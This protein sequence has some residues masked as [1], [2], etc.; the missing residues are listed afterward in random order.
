VALAVAVS[1]VVISV[2]VGVSS[3]EVFPC[4]SGA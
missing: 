2:I 4:A 3:L 1:T